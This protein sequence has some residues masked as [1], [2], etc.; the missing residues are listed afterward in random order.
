[1]LHA[2]HSM[3]RTGNTTD[4]SHGVEKN[5]RQKKG[6]WKS[7]KSMKACDDGVA[8]CEMRQWRRKET[9]GSTSVS[10]KEDLDAF[11]TARFRGQHG[12]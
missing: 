11:A 8:A 3:R 2:T 6:A 9:S 4:L 5:V 10:E 12:L 1:M 7:M